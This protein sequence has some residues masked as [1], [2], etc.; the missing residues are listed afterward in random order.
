MVLDWE[1]FSPITSEDMREHPR[2]CHAP[3]VVL[4]WFKIGLGPLQMQLTICKIQEACSLLGLVGT[5]GE[6]Q[7]WGPT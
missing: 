4:L 1:M 5:G 2:H 3:N 6:D 7:F